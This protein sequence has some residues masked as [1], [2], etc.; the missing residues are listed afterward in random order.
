MTISDSP[1]FQLEYTLYKM[2]YYVP[3]SNQIQSNLG[4]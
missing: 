4:Q 2:D 3:Q 1:V